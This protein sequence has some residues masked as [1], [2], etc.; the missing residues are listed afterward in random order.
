MGARDL[1]NPDEPRYA[2]V[3]REMLETGDWIVPHLNG[4]VYPEKPPLYFW[5]VALL[6]KPF[7]D[8]TETTARFPSAMA[9]TLIVIIT[10]FLGTKM[11]G[12]R[13]AFWGALITATSTQVF[14]IGRMGVIDS[15]LT[16]CMLAALTMFYVGYVGKHE[17]LYPAGFLFLA[18]AALSKGPVGVAVPLFVMIAFLFLEIFLR[19]EGSRRQLAWFALGTLLGLLVVAFFVV[20]WWKAAYERSD[21]V[22]GSLSILAK[23]TKGRMFDSYSH[24]KPFYY[25]GIHI[26]WLFLPWIVFFPLAAHTIK[27]RGNLREHTGLRF[28]LVWLVGVFLFFTL[29][30]GK[31][32]QYIL[33]LGPA[34]GLLV[35]WALVNANPAGGRLRDRREFSLPLLMLIVLC[36]IGVVALMV[37]MHLFFPERFWAGSIVLLV[38]AAA[39]LLLHRELLNR[40]PTHALRVLAVET[41]IV[42]A[43]FFGFVGPAI[44]K[45]KSA[46]A[47]CN[48]LSAAA[49]EGEELFFYRSIRP[50]INY[51]MHQRI[52]VLRSN[53]EI[54]K[55]L[56]GARRLLLIVQ[57]KHMDSL[58][59]EAPY[60][61]E[62]RIRAKIGSRDMWCMS[63]AE[64]S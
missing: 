64:A 43:V 27:R 29:I 24:R 11:V 5:L 2:Q 12:R 56:S 4:E 21:G 28:L 6:S 7:G 26:L 50:D 44:D 20:P 36:I 45:Y 1:W 51:Y 48:E 22:Y 3:A 46:R 59:V 9:T 58:A 19:R 54:A 55:A 14:S 13:E 30:S 40:P 10:Y 18:L 32:S 39:L 35:G 49:Q 8:V 37:G 25:Y 62:Q 53:E 63:I 41:T 47:F 42:I 57:W 23:Q 16:L 61:M 33:P 31:R 38:A 15:L 60:V 34:G 17:L 52:P